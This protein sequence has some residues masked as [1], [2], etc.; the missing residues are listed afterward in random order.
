MD[1]L[2]RPTETPRSG[3]GITWPPS[4]LPMAD[5]DNAFYVDQTLKHLSVREDREWL[6]FLAFMRPHPPFVAHAPW[7]DMFDPAD[8]PAPRRAATKAE[9][10]AQHPLIAHLLDTV[11]ARDFFPQGE[12]LISDLSDLDVAQVMATYFGMIAELD[13]QIGRVLDWLE[14]TSQEPLIVFTSDHGELLGDHYLFGKAG[15]FEAGFRI[16]LV[17]VEPGGEARSVD[18]PTESVD[19]MP[20]ILDWLGLPIPRACDGLSLVPWMRGE[21]PPWRSGVMLEFD[22]RQ[23]KDP[24]PLGLDPDHAAAA[25]WR[26]TKTSF[27]HFVDLPPLH[28]DLLNDPQELRNLGTVSSDAAAK[29]LSRRIAHADRTLTGF[30]AGPAGWP[31]CP[32]SH[33]GGDTYEDL[34]NGCL[35]GS[36]VSCAASDRARSRASFHSLPVRQSRCTSR[37]PSTSSRPRIR[38][39]P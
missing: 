9:E 5:G 6:M 15:P 33:S 21:T 10:A 25:T 38:A 2:W 13:H 28:Y 4:P 32:T 26:D 34:Q 27:T 30:Q 22:L 19:I 37:D 31:T 11:K 7:H 18:A 8:M 17:I 1:A 16:P 36:H 3:R 12:G 39:L 20:T 29:L 24:T 14:A 23:I 35:C